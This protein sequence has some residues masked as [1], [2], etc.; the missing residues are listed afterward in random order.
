[1]RKEYI[2]TCLLFFSIAVSTFAQ[3]DSECEQTLT[4]AQDEFD[5]GHF[6][7]LPS[8]LKDCLSKFSTEQ[9]VRAYLL[10]A[11]SYL[12]IDDPIAAEDSYMKLLRADPEYVADVSKDPI[13][14]FYLSKKFTTT[15]IF[16][17]HI[18]VGGNTSVYR[19]IHEVNP[20]PEAVNVQHNLRF[21][22]QAGGGID[23]NI[24][25]NLSLCTEITFSRKVFQIRYNGI[26][27]LDNLSYVEKQNWFDIP[28]YVK[29]A[30]SEGKIRPFG[31]AGYALNILA[32]PKAELRFI[33]KTNSTTDANVSEFPTTGPDI[34]L[35]YKREVFNR[36]FVMGGGFRY[37]VGKD[38]FFADV[39][40]MPGLT[41]L[42]KKET[43]FYESKKGSA[44]EFAFADSGTKYT[45][46][47][48]D[49]RLDNVSIS[50]GYVKPIYHPSKVKKMRTGRTMRKVSREKKNDG[51]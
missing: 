20:Y 36:S 4:Q 2:F 35:G 30:A 12:L 8:I 49:F 41:N 6:Y 28:L 46:I 17:P 40:Y 37:K 15:P 13:D 23:W 32:G 33:N 47:G 10:L 34:K 14:I 39:R 16:T 44:D 24:N 3:N 7:G 1:M 51:Q 42:S 18:R 29:Y 5:A 19:L 27:G 26:F 38:F 22:F 21:A 50:I 25:E 9:S 11:Q 43:N 45:F 48:N 31:Y